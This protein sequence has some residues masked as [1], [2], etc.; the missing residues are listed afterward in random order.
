MED[1][2]DNRPGKDW[3]Y[4][5]LARNKLTMR[6]SSALESYRASACTEDKL[7]KW[8]CDFEQ[9]LLTPWIT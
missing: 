4:G 7:R 9:L 8:Y 6:S 2:I 1:Q 5:F 3:W